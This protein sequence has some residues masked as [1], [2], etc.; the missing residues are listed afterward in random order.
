MALTDYFYK[1]THSKEIA[2]LEETFKIQCE[3]IISI[4][5]ENVLYEQCTSPEDLSELKNDFLESENCQSEDEFWLKFQSE[6]YIMEGQNWLVE[7][8]DEEQVRITKNA[9][10]V[11]LIMTKDF[12]DAFSDI[13][14]N[15]YFPIE[16]A[17]FKAI[18]NL[19]PCTNN[20]QNGLPAGAY[21]RYKQIVKILLELRYFMRK[22]YV[23][24]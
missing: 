1:M 7:K 19:H 16:N 3:R 2:R 21:I 18:W 5:K 4:W 17:Y 9:F 15:D 20:P 11:R 14:N 8:I 24:E 6:A 22:Y 10:R 13:M 23:V 12:E